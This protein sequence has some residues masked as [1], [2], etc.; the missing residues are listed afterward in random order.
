V[1]DAGL[2]CHH[3]SVDPTAL[4]WRSNTLGGLPPVA[5]ERAARQPELRA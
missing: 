3:D 5:S 1:A 2:L 4:A